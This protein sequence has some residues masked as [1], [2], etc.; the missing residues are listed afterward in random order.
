MRNALRI[1]LGTLAFGLV[2]ACTVHE[3][4]A[5][6]LQGPSELALRL[7][8]TAI[9]DSI[10]QDGNS[11][12]AVTISASG[13]DGRPIAG[14][15]VRI[16][17]SAEGLIQDFGRLSSKSAV[18]GGDGVARVTYTAP[19]GPLVSTTSGSVVTL[20]V[21]PIGN[22]YRGE[23]P[24]TVDIRLVPQGVILP[25]DGAPTAAFTISPSPASTFTTVFFDASGS[26]DEGVPCGARCTYSW[27]F[28]DGG[29]ASGVTATHEYRSAG[30]FTI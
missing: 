7:A 6:A 3:Q 2:G 21:T 17:M 19:P 9:P 28:G 5:P 29:T 1:L 26:T 10:L 14:L 18:T 4:E 13:P 15:A 8:L 23:I 24:R 22:D 16:D 12:S 11:Q 27:N 25:P 30:T 20:L